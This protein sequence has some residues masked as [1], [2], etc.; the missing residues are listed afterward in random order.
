MDKI[1]G[2]IEGH[3]HSGVTDRASYRAVH[4]K[5][6]RAAEK[7]VF[8]VDSRVDAY[9]NHG[10]WVVDCKCN[11]A[12]LTSPDFGMT[13]CFDCGRVYIA[14]NFP[15]N[16]KQIERVLLLRKDTANRNWSH[17]ETVEY[18]SIESEAG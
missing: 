5:A 8:E 3:G 1:T 9:V 6:M 2:P 15:N 12:G 13:C 17:G 11:G 4:A 14:V 10:R 18:L 16:R 7:E